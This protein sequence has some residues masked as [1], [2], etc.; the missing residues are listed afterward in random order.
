MDLGVPQP[1]LQKLT[2]DMTSVEAAPQNLDLE[3]QLKIG[4]V[5]WSAR[6]ANT[7][8]ACIYT[9][10][11]EHQLWDRT[12]V[13]IATVNHAVEVEWP[14]KWAESVGQAIWYANMLQKDPVVCLLMGS[15]KA[16]DKYVYRLLNV[17]QAIGIAV[18]MCHIK[19]ETLR[20]HELCYPL[21]DWK[22]EPQVLKAD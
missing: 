10:E 12:R 15:C 2:M 11:A 22:L 4:E 5:A 16:E 20:V 19:E 21:V 3:L 18:W 14:W 13:D 8:S 6:I 1:L 7:L 9:A 17:C